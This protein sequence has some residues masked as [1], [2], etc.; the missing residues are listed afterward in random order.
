MLSW[1]CSPDG[2][3]RRKKVVKRKL[4][5][6]AAMLAVVMLAGC[7][8]GAESGSTTAETGKAQV[9][10]TAGEPVEI[11]FWYGLGGTLGETVEALIAEF[12]ASQDEVEVKGVAQSSY[13]ETSQM[14]QAAIASGDVPACFL[15]SYQDLATFAEKGVVEYL[16]S[17]IAAD[18]DFN[19]DDILDSFM[20]YCRDSEGKVYGLPVWGSTQVIYYRKD[21]FEEVGLDPDEVFATWQNLAEACRTLKEY[22]KDVPNF[23]GFDPMY[24]SDHI[25]EIAYSNGASIVS[26]DGKTV[27]FNSDAFVEACE[28]VRQWIHEDQIMRIHFGGE[29]WEYW[30]KTIDDV[31]QGR[32]AGYMGSSGDQADLDFDIIAAHVQPGFNDNPPK[33]YVDPITV[34]IVGKASEEQKQAAF[35]WLTFLNQ[36][37]TKEFSMQSGYVPV[38]A[39]V[40]ED[41]EYK[42]Y[43]EENPQAQA[44]L[45]QAEIGRKKWIDP[46]GAVL[47]ALDDAVDLIEIEN[48]PAKEAL[49]EAAAIAQQGL[50]E[51]WANQGE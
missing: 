9:Q 46:T 40:K 17:Y 43:M 36:T 16:D 34:G 41:E 45:E 37:G 5:T 48:V 19:P 11:E 47:Q 15:S 18:P 38:R 6:L 31:M 4:R 42:A 23:Y 32:S 7:G 26:E 10:D 20:S 44:I 28:A 21:M 2:R 8:N 50:D 24:G 14:L 22:Y 49:D 27:T 35:K 39:S 12:N 13:G 3:K 51:Y 1:Q 25:M 30:Y 33:P 29:G